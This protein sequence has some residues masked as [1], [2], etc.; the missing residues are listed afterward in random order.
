MISRFVDDEAGVRRQPGE[1]LDLS[2]ERVERLT[3]KNC[4]KRK[5]GRPAG[6]S[7]KATPEAESAP[8]TAASEGD[9]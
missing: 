2:D 6:G 4:V 9:Q 1:E 7:R 8:T 5:A 3:R